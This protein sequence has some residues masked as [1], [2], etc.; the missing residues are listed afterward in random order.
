MERKEGKVK[1]YSPAGTTEGGKTGYTLATNCAGDKPFV[2]DVID[3]SRAA[4][5][6][7]SR[8]ILLSFKTTN[9]M[10]PIMM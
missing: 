1:H 7:F 10:T 2:D 8:A 4:N 6:C 9:I 3:S 5:I